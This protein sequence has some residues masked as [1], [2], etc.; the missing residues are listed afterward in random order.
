MAV[1]REQSRRPNLSSETPSLGRSD[2]TLANLHQDTP[3]LLAYQT[4][5]VGE[6]LQALA[7]TE[8]KATFVGAIRE[9]R[10]HFRSL[11]AQH[12]GLS[13]TSDGAC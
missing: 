8:V 2:Q 12:S 1:W 4:V 5:L 13:R 11:Q 9:P 10:G 7:A 6:A 3:R